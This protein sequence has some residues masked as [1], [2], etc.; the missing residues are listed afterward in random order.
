MVLFVQPMDVYCLEGS[1]SPGLESCASDCS[2]REGK[3][4]LSEWTGPLLVLRTSEPGAGC[5][6]SAFAGTVKIYHIKLS[7]AI[8][9]FHSFATVAENHK[10]VGFKRATLAI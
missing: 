6:C 2:N 5:R 1:R 7:L 8:K 3:A 4:D 10:F 9:Y